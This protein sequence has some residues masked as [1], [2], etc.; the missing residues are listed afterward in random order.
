[1][2]RTNGEILMKRKLLSVILSIAIVVSFM[3]MQVCCA[4]AKVNT[5]AT[6]ST[7]AGLKKAF[8]NKS[9]KTITISTTKERTFKIPSVNHKKVSLILKS[10]TVLSGINK[11]ISKIT[12]SR[13]SKITIKSSLASNIKIIVA[14]GV[15][16]DIANKTKSTNITVRNSKGEIVAK[17]GAGQSGSVT[18]DKNGAKKIE[19]KQGGEKSNSG[20]KDDPK[21]DKETSADA[22]K[23]SEN[24]E[25]TSAD[26]GETQE[27]PEEK[28]KKENKKEEDKD[29]HTK[30]I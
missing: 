18:L 8:R 19:Q 16:A 17:I 13:D 7:Q 4:S 2:Q 29:T 28:Q 21:K 30:R 3:P 5:K 14:S 25:E 9:L 22:T 20:K 11:N 23:D 15:K 6:V 12:V 27:K 1:M 24:I 26:A 10:N